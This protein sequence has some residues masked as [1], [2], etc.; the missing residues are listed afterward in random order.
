MTP[1]VAL[2][3]IQRSFMRNTFIFLLFLLLIPQLCFA[4]RATELKNL[5]DEFTFFQEVEWDQRDQVIYHA[6]KTQFEK[7][8]IYLYQHGL[9]LDDV[10]HVTS[11][12]LG[13]LH[14]DNTSELRDF[15]L[16]FRN[17]KKGANWNGDVLG[18]VL[19]ISVIGIAVGV[20]MVMIIKANQKFDAC[21]AANNG[22]EEPCIDRGL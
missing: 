8:L 13:R 5:I 3:A 16:Q 14:F 6:K 12:D 4:S 15:L 7:D 18:P 19:G 2:S 21:V 17:Y 20:V 1:L 11:A 10:K 22:D 9:T